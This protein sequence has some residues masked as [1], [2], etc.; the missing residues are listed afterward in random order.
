MVF[1]IAH[2]RMFAHLF[3]QKI[4]N[5]LGDIRAYYCLLFSLHPFALERN[6]QCSMLRRWKCQ[7]VDY[8]YSVITR[9]CL[10]VE[11][12]ILDGCVRAIKRIRM[13]G[14]YISSN[15][16]TLRLIS[17]RSFVGSNYIA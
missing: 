9:Y 15:I 3:R 5:C 10:D 14:S 11:V 6:Q 17:N 7:P 13:I 16:R 2:L 8:C 12:G 4:N 1:P